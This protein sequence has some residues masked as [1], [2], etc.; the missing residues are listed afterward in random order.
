MSNGKDENRLLIV[1]VDNRV[2]EPCDQNTTNRQINGCAGIRILA[3]E[4][5][6]ALNLGS[7]RP[8]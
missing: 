3:N 4:R 7:E 1:P 6:S 8:A 2:W 5:D